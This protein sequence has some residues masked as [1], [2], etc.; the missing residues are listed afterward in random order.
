MSLISLA[1]DL[2]RQVKDRHDDRRL[3]RRI[4]RQRTRV[5]ELLV[6]GN[7]DEA[8]DAFASLRLLIAQRRPE[9]VARMEVERGLRNG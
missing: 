6:A 1:G 2:C 8:R 5:A 4:D 9:Q 3:E 7:M